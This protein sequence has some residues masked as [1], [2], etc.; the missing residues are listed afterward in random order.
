VRSEATAV[1]GCA[2]HLARAIAVAATAAATVAAGAAAGAVAATGVTAGGLLGRAACRASARLA[3]LTIRIELLVACGEREFRSAVS[4]GQRLV[5][6]RV[7]K[8]NTPFRAASA[9]HLAVKP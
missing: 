3:E 5:G 9:S 1:A 2:E 4:A 7:Q 8:K 6:K